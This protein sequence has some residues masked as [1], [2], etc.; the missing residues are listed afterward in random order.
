MCANVHEE[1]VPRAGAHQL[2][3]RTGAAASS[4][5]RWVGLSYRRHQSSSRAPTAGQLRQLARPLSRGSGAPMAGGVRCATLWR[6]GADEHEAWLS[7]FVNPVACKVRPRMGTDKLLGPLRPAA[8]ASVRRTDRGTF[9]RLAERSH[10]WGN[11][12]TA[13]NGPKTLLVKDH[14]PGSL[15]IPSR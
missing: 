6:A 12:M 1:R 3:L 11:T 10:A 5:D 13:P 7:A 9:R 8:A 2:Q 14:R 4:K 15:G